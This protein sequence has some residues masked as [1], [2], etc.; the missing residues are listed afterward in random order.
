ML[1]LLYFISYFDY[2]KLLN[3]F[4]YLNNVNEYIEK[5]KITVKYSTLRW[6]I[7]RLQFIDTYQKQGKAA[8]KIS[9]RDTT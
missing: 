8:L 1:V 7:D 9:T 2:Q 3:Y 4:F 5:G 6:L